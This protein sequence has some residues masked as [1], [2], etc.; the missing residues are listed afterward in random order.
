MGRRI[1]PAMVSQT[2]RWDAARQSRGCGGVP[3]R[4]V[5]RRLGGSRLVA[6]PAGA[7]FHRRRHPAAGL[8]RARRAHPGRIDALEG[9]TAAALQRRACLESGR[10]V[11]A[12]AVHGGCRCLPVAG[13]VLVRR[14]RGGR[15]SV[16]L[17]GARLACRQRPAADRCGRAGHAVRRGVHPG[18]RCAR[19][20]P[21]CL[22]SAGRGAGRRVDDRRPGDCAVRTSGPDRRRARARPAGRVGGSRGVLPRLCGGGRREGV[23]AGN[24][25]GVPGVG[26]ALPHRRPASVVDQ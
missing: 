3:R 18:Q 25:P 5:G 23:R 17:S 1:G 6:A 16:R 21:G 22:E 24:R 14:G 15:A 20:D 11:L 13:L 2:G 7:E 4:G 9:E 8:V 19:R 26:R 12:A 10:R